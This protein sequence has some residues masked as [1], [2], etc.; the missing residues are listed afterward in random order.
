MDRKFKPD[1]AGFPSHHLPEWWL[2]QAA[3]PQLFWAAVV[4]GLDGIRL[5]LQDGQMILF[6]DPDDV[7]HWLS[8]E[9]FSPLDDLRADG[10]VARDLKPPSEGFFCIST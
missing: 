5:H 10:E 3:L 1:S 2:D 4:M 7:I 9:E 6:D 8:E